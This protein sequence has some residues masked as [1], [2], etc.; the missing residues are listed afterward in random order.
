[1]CPKK[2]VCLPLHSIYEGDGSLATP[3]LRTLVAGTGPAHP[4]APVR[5]AIDRC[6]YGGHNGVCSELSDGFVSNATT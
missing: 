5:L 1:M 4:V 6:A 2:V 3:P